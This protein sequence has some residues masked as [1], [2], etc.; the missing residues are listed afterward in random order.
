[1]SDDD[2]H[3]PLLVTL[4]AAL[5]ARVQALAAARGITAEAFILDQLALALDDGAASVADDWAEDLRR[6]SEGGEGVPA[7]AVFDRLEA[8]LAAARL[9][10]K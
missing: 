2:V 6:L 10:A 3:H 8:H 7:E 5:A 1:M 4:P 9:P